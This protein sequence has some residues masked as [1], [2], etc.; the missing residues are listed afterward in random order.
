M[1]AGAE[2]GFLAGKLLARGDYHD[3][4]GIYSGGTARPATPENVAEFG[5]PKVQ[6]VRKFPATFNSDHWPPLIRATVA[7]AGLAIADI[8]LFIF[9]QLNLRTIEFMMDNLGQP[10][11]KT[12]TIMDKWGYLGSACIP[13]ALDDAITSGRGPKPGDNVVFCASGGGL[14]MAASVWRW[15]G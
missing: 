10:M 15:V 3:A 4:L 14:T 13:A 1:R 6:F 2:P 9:T 5:K 8:D 12:H 7:K 11:S